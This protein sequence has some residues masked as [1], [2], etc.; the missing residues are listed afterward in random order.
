MPRLS[1]QLALT[2]GIIVGRMLLG[3]TSWAAAQSRPI[4][5]DTLGNERS[6]VVPLDSSLPGDRIEGGAR[7]GDNLFHSLQQLNVDPGRSVY[8]SDPGVDNIITRVT[9]GTSSQIDGILGVSGN[10]NL[11]LINPSGIIFGANAR[12]DV[13]GSFTATTADAL[14]FG[15]RGD[16]SATNPTAPPL[17]TVQPSAFLFNQINPAP[18]ASNSKIEL[19]DNPSGATGFGLRVLEGEGLTLLGGNISMD[20]GGLN[21][22]GGRVEIGGL[23]APGTVSR[24]TDGSLSFPDGIARADVSLTNQSLIDVA[25]DGGGSI[26]INAGDLEISGSVLSAGIGRNSGFIGAQAGDITLIANTI[27]GRESARIRNQVRVSGIGNAGNISIA[28]G[29][30]SLTDGTRLQANTFG[31]GN[32][33]DVFINASKDV[34]LNNSI[35]FS[36]VG[37]VS[38]D[39][40]A[41]GE[42]G[43]IYITTGSLSLADGAQLQ[44][45]TFGQGDAGDVIINAREGV[46]L[47][48][49][50]AIFSSV[51]TTE[52]MQAV[53]EGGDIRITTGS[54]ALTD[55]AALVA[56]T[57]GQGNAGNV[58]INASEGVSLHNSSIYSSVGTADNKQ[59]IGEGGNI[60]ITAGSISLAD[61]AQLQ[62]NTFGQGNAGNVIIDA[63]D[64]VNIEG[65]NQQGFLSAIITASQAS[66]EGQGGDI[67]I[68]ADSIRIADGA[69]VSAETSSRFGGGSVT[70]NAKTF[71]AI[72]GGK[73][74][75]DTDGRGGAGNITINAKSRITLFGSNPSNIPINDL[76]A[77]GLYANTLDSS[78]SGG[79]VKVTTGKLEV[80]D[81]ATIAVS[82]EGEGRAGDIDITANRVHLNN[83]SRLSAETTTVKGGNITLNN[84]ELLQL[85]NSSLISTT[86][87]TANAGGNGGNINIDSDLIVAFPK[88]NSDIRANAFTG[89]GGNVSIDS[90][91]LFGIAFQAQDNPIT[92]DIT[93]SSEQGLQGNVNIEL[94]EIDPRRDLTQLPQEVV[95]VSS[96]IAQGCRDSNGARQNRGEFIVKGRGGLPPSPTDSL[97]GDESLANWVT[98]EQTSRQEKTTTTIPT[99]ETRTTA[100]PIVE[101]QG[102][103]VD[104][105]GKVTLIATAPT[106]AAQ[107]N[108]IC[109]K[110]ENK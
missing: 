50:S 103:I 86:A 93:A 62:A 28:T 73:V 79:T 88:E 66:A 75:T 70:F 39:T 90:Q 19:G 110:Q 53:G 83:S 40:Q 43:N 16:F 109:Q 35:I 106:S 100:A 97:V 36:S 69:V 99:P 6:V 2:S 45:N 49:S 64:R 37:D 48:G 96:R 68:A 91:G 18:I 57:I 108:L 10:A 41:I 85:R 21:A 29:S 24:N 22:L 105:N 33:G 5:D 74:N 56:I 60:D 44:A 92:N 52:T 59:A 1:W 38:A 23:S 20:G 77:T 4:A 17:L 95:D 7:R 8:F 104:K 34:S 89:S 54:L 107:A 72:G 63:R 47:N 25:A 84:V 32:A 65:I 31:Q 14:E 94:P 3:W 9:G 78:G 76:E 71:E 51:D 27:R 26:T 55:S 61:G 80:F 13:S 102:W 58:I 87:G 81:G 101:A 30:L 42:G 98:L 12:L 11:F 15:E 46:A 82:S 67:R